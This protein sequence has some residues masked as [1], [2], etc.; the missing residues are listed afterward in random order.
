MTKHGSR[1]NGAVVQW[2]QWLFKLGVGV[3]LLMWLWRSGRFDARVADQWRW[4]PAAA[5]IVVSQIAIIVLQAARW[6]ILMR[7]RGLPLPARAIVVASLRGQFASV[8]TP[9]N[10]GLD[11]VRLWQATRLYPQRAGI[12][13]VLLCDRLAGL[14]ALLALVV[15]APLWHREAHL[16]ILSF[17]AFSALCAGAAILLWAR[18]STATSHQ[19]P[20]NGEDSGAEALAA[21]DGLG[22]AAR[23]RLRLAGAVRWPHARREQWTAVALIS[24]ANHI[25]NALAFAGAFAMLGQKPPL[26]TIIAIVPSVILSSVVPLTPLGLG[27]SDAVSQLLFG[28]VGWTGGAAVTMIGRATWLLLSL[29][30]GGAYFARTPH[31][32][33]PPDPKVL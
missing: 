3:A 4:G 31:F 13:S 16:Q 22:R 1:F 20:N 33:S 11:G 10:L 6:S 29:V 21:R 19:A 17:A 5:V 26:T 9:S 12:L 30:C 15:V 24:V 23:F 14:A 18:H 32:A 8:W 2:A 28:A 27:V 7:A 25:F